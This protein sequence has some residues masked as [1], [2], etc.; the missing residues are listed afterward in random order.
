MAKPT[1]KN[2]T[3]PIEKLM[4][5]F[6]TILPAFLA[7]VRPASTS[8]KPACMN[9]TSTVATSTNTLSRV[10]CKPGTRVCKSSNDGGAS[11]AAR[12]NPGIAKAPRVPLSAVTPP[13]MV[14][15]FNVFSFENRRF[16]R[17]D[18][19]GQE[20]R[21]WLLPANNKRPRFRGCQGCVS[22]MFSLDALTFR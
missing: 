16:V 5:F 18:D 13:L 15:G 9:T 8:T 10:T 1:T 11:C 17:R 7:R 22:R 20:R 3:A 2:T 4:R 6:M 19:Y 12:T 21:R 14:N